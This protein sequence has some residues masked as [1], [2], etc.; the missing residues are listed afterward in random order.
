MYV[1]NMQLPLTYRVLHCSAVRPS[2]QQLA[3]IQA[4][5]SPMG[6]VTAFLVVL[7]IMCLSLSVAYLGISIVS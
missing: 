1:C 6:A 3:V 2:A 5:G 4:E 7:V